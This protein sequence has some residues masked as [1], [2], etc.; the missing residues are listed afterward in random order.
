MTNFIHDFN[1]K[2]ITEFRATQGKMDS[3]A[4]QELITMMTGGKA[5]ER[6]NPPLLLLTTIG[7]KSGQPR[8]APLAYTTDGDRFVIIASK[9]GAPSNPDWYYNLVANPTV[10]VEV[11]D[12][13][14]QARAVVP[15]GQERDR[16]Y[17]KMAEQLPQFNEYQQKTSRKIPVVVLERAG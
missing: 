17:A 5:S 6:K 15:E 13:K 1:R 11:G 14:F 2:F 10:T 9:G 3:P 8:L 4:G 16:L 12:Q 7:A